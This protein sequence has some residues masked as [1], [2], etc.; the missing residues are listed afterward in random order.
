MSDSNLIFAAMG[1][2]LK[3]CQAIAKDR[4]NKQQGFQY[5]G[6]DDAYNALHPVMAKHGVFTVPRCISRDQVERTTK[7]GGALFYTVVNMEYDFVCAGD[8]SKITVG[9][10][11]G[12]AMDT[13]DKSSNKAMATAHKYCLF[14]T[15]L[16]P[17]EK[18]D[19]DAESY[20]VE[21]VAPA[22][23]EQMITINDYLESDLKEETKAWIRK[24]LPMNQSQATTVINKLKENT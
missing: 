21:T 17:T 6:V 4:R 10:V 22:T 1:S 3:D 7:S 8:G 19:A 20:E 14:Q 18:E 15:F 13:A 12:E 16:I 2:I 24:H 5:R 23:D 11:I 9:P